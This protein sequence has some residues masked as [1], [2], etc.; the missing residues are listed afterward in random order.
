MASAAGDALAGH[1]RYAM[2]DMD[3]GRLA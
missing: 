3:D 2:S 1:I